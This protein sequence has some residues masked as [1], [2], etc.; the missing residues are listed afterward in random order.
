MLVGLAF[1]LGLVVAP[2]ARA[3]L[4]RLRWGVGLSIVVVLS[5]PWFIYMWHRFGNDFITGYAL[6]E[7]L[8]LY[9]VPT[10]GAQRSYFFYPKVM[11]IGLLPW[12]PL[13]AGRLIDAFLGTGSRQPSAFSGRGRSR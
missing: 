9:A 13:L 4:W 8:W 6:K 1:L 3:P 7:N 11:A 2:E 5:S 12:T 10:Y